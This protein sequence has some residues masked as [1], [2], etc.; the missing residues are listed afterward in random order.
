MIHRVTNR[1]LLIVAIACAS[2]ASQYCAQADA[3]KPLTKQ[4][5]TVLRSFVT[6][7]LQQGGL[8][9]DAAF[10]D[11]TTAL[12]AL[13]PALKNIASFLKT[14]ENPKLR[15]LVFFLV[16]EVPDIDKV[17]KGYDNSEIFKGLFTTS[18]AKGFDPKK[19]L[20]ATFRRLIT[21]A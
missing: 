15:Q 3:E 12:E 14:I 19:T 6:K 17:F 11:D 8:I 7:K 10:S 5:K 21:G 13:E 20:D 18:Q 4:A 9:Y 1:Y 2:L 16:W